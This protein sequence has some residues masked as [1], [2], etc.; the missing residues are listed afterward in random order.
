VAFVSFAQNAEDLM[1]WRALRHVERGFWID[2]GAAD[3][4]E[5]SV[6]RAFHDRGWS[7]INVEPGAHYFER[8]RAARPGDVNL[9]VA[10]GAQN[11]SRPFHLIEGT[12]LSTLDAELARTHARSGFQIRTEAIE[13]C[14][15]A[16]ICRWHVTGP[17]HFLKVD[18]EGAE[19]EVLAG[20]D[21]DQYRP[22]IVLVEATVPLTSEPSESAWE[23]ALL[24][25]GYVFAWFDGLNRFYVACEQE[26]A[27]APALR[28]P[29]HLADD[30]MTADDRDR[31][32]RVDALEAELAGLRRL[33]GRAGLEI[34]RQRV[35]A[36]VSVAGRD[37]ALRERDAAIVEAAWLRRSLDALN[38]PA[39]VM[40]ADPVVAETPP[41]IAPAS[42]PAPL[43]APQAG[44]SRRLAGRA[45][46]PFWRVVRP[47]ARPLAWRARTFLTAELREDVRRAL[48][49]SRESVDAG[50]NEFD[51]HRGSSAEPLRLPPP[52]PGR[53]HGRAPLRAVHQFHPTVE[54]RDAITNAM[55]LTRDLLRGLGFDS[56]I[57][58]Q[59][60]EGVSPDDARL[61]DDLPVHDGYVL[62]VHHSLGY[63]GADRIA[64]LPAPKL[65]VY[66]NITPPSLLG[67]A[68][69]QAMAELGREQLAFWRPRVRAAIGDSEYNAIELRRA[70][71]PV[72]S[73]CQLLFDV[74]RLRGD[75]AALREA[76]LPASPLTILFVGRV[77][78]SKGQA[79]L[80]DAYAAFRSLYGESASRLVLVGRTFAGAE[81]YEAEIR[82]RIARHGLQSSVVLAGAVDDDALRGWYGRADI[83]ASMSRHEGFGVPL[84]EAMAYGLPV[85]ALSAG[86]VALTVG[87]AGIVVENALQM[88]DALLALANGGAHAP[89]LERARAARLESFGLERQVPKLLEA[90]AVAGAL[91]PAFVDRD[92]LRSALT[93]TVAG[94]VHGSYSLA[95]VNRALALSLDAAAPRRIGLLPVEGEPLPTLVVGPDAVERDRLLALAE[96]ERAWA[97]AQAVI[98]QHYPVWVPPF[99]PG[100]LRLAYLFWEESLLPDATI[101]T[102]NRNFDAVL[103]PT[104][105]VAKALVDSG[106]TTPVRIVGFAPPLDRFAALAHRPERGQDRPFTFL[107]VSSGFPRKG[108]D[109]LLDAYAR[110]FGLGERVRLV[111]KTFP[112]PHND[113]AE[114]IVA[115]RERHPELCEIVHLDG[116][117]TASELESL[118]LGAD[119]A[120]LPSRGEGF[121]IPAAEAMAAGVPLIVSAVGGHRDFVQAD[122]VWLIGGRHGPSGSHLAS[123]G[124]LWFE[125]D[126]E[127]LV[128]AMRAVVDRP[129]EARARAERARG[130][131]LAAL[132]PDRFAGGV[133]DAVAGLMAEPA[134]PGG[135]S[136]IAVMT[137]WGVRCGIA[138]YAAL[139]IGALPP[140]G[141][142]LTIL[143]DDRSEPHDGRPS[144]RAA[145]RLG[146]RFDVEQT[147]SAI[148]QEDPDILLVQ[149]QP[150]LFSWSGLADLLSDTRVHRR[151][152]VVTLHNTRSLEALDEAERTRV[153]GS[154]ARASRLIVHAP[155][156]QDRL[157]AMQVF[158][159]TTVPHGTLSPP[160][161][162]KP[163]RTLLAGDAPVIG[164]YGFLLPPKNFG[165]LIEAL[166][167]LRRSW[168]KARLRMVTALYDQGPSEAEHHRLRRLAHDVGVGG[169]IDWHTGFLPTETSLE[170]LAGCDLLVMPYEPTLEA[171][172]GALR[173]A[174]ASLVPTAVT[175]ID[176]FRDAGPAVALLPGGSAAEIASGVATLLQDPDRRR[177]LVDRQE[178]WLAGRS[179]EK[180]GR[181]VLRM[182][183]A[184]YAQEGRPGASSVS[185]LRTTPLDPAKG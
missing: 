176:I 91:R 132:G 161:R 64:A 154:F 59:H 175:P 77:V 163:A 89:G 33:Q 179:W 178:T 110:A 62:M 103:A 104:R 24:A 69:L 86:A 87:D 159:A 72:V 147:A 177:A 3:P 129:E 36:A 2:A 6:T 113:V 38:E 85:V 168:P 181:R 116:E 84:V 95:A 111:I 119:A 40:T 152:V 32:V 29:P 37:D 93:L 71:Y 23:P 184:L 167:I 172:S 49:R 55:L 43:P 182:L 44:G 102:L 16:Q 88:S 82:Q 169:E 34:E 61:L 156:D 76:S 21:W 20:A 75:A 73:A 143:A 81:P 114:R 158:N 133:L 126:V 138:E 185:V 100:Q 173:I 54:A 17:I 180:V 160:A 166:P 127:A 52:D 109:L 15:L 60:R 162:P 8:L 9:R 19:A 112:N 66:H 10:L 122:T 41:A 136:R 45:L 148:A 124:A 5:M 14:T 164:A 134:L 30:W 51:R 26:Q 153:V 99:R 139:L 78:P 121:N 56:E 115:L 101:D 18:V 117:L 98:S 128:E 108:V 12:G 28:L 80:V 22:W 35:L 146:D 141:A 135:P 183:E 31:R 46:L 118:Y 48:E 4:D 142:S 53:P 63:P 144:V 120:V 174:L 68:F 7:G 140:T 106:V 137:S 105:F 11:G 57:Y 74:E 165:A 131:V 47:V 130:T 27:L 67:D 70:G 107:H 151:T 96:R 90:L 97:G 125:P 150:G 25:A 149:H 123:G 42:L 170:L 83:Y 39:P 94:H 145:W 65:L 157:S 13:V 171:A 155:A 79:D 50:E 58:V 1:L 92:A